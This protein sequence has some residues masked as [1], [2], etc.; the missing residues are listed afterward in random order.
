VAALRYGRQGGLLYK[1][2]QEIAT[3]HNMPFSQVKNSGN[4]IVPRSGGDS[5]EE[6]SIKNWRRIAY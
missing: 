5:R 3:L 4:K 2:S 1:L 6:R